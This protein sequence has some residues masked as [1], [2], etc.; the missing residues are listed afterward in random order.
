MSCVNEQ[1]ILI[2]SA[3]GTDLSPIKPLIDKKIPVICAD[4][5]IETALDAGI[6][7][8]FFIGDLDSGS[9]PENVECIILP[10]E[11]D[12]TD[13]HTALL[14]AIEQGARYVYITGCTNGRA[15]HYFANL[16]LL[17]M[18]SDH[19]VRGVI[20]DKQNRI[21]FHSGGKVTL[22]RSSSALFRS[23][24]EI[25]I[26]DDFKYISIL[27]LD[28]ELTGITLKGFKYPLCNATIK[29]QCPIGVSNELISEQGEICT[30]G[31]RAFVILSKD[32]K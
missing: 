19:G 26:P 29:R 6:V 31:G 4:G 1:W 9:K 2:G 27:P 20:M 22:K 21:F 23:E 30:Q 24:D 8:N 11:K 13:L 3:P 10:T 17:E 18:L 12:Y 7:P 5:G 15:D 32:V 16:L 28:G 14:W 25:L